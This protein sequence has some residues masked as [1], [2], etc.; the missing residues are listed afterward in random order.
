VKLKISPLFISS[1]KLTTTTTSQVQFSQTNNILNKINNFIKDIK[2]ALF[3][4]F[5]F[6]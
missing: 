1:K 2:T 5:F 4:L 6:C 3:D